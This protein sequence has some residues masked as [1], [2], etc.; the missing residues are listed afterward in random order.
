MILR[1]LLCCGET[2]T[3]G[4]GLKHACGRKQI[5]KELG[6]AGVILLNY[7]A[8]L[9]ADSKHIVSGTKELKLSRHTNYI[10]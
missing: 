5:S 1:Q 7:I 4:T 8:L 2:K 9:T 3:T 6:G 10:W